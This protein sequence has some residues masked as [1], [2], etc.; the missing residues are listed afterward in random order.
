VA[1]ECACPGP[2]IHWCDEWITNLFP[3]SYQKEKMAI[4]GKECIIN[5]DGDAFPSKEV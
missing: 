5:I 2:A 1:W 4:W 3:K